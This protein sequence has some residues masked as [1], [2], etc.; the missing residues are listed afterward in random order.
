[1]PR[2]RLTSFRFAFEGIVHVMK[3]QP[4][5]WAHA[6]ISLAVVLVGLWV[7]LSRIEWAI[8]IAMMAGVWVAEFLNTAIEAAI[9]TA[10]R[11]RHPL[12]K[13]AK[14][15]AAGGVLVAAILAV[16]VGLLIL[17]PPVWAR[18]LGGS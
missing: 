16:I 15:T 17:G 10:T 14:D 6:A 13:I 7:G 12:A 18:L 5:A 2:F 3:T 8:L 9:D 1:M 4:N 11:E